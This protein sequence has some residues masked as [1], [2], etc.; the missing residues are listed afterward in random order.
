MAINKVEYN[1]E[2]LMDLTEDT[3]TEETLASGV[4]AHNAAGEP[5]TGTMTGGV[6]SDWAQTDETQLD[7]IKNKPEIKSEA[8]KDDSSLITSGGVYEA[9]ENG[10]EIVYIPVELGFNESGMPITATLVGVTHADI[11]GYIEQGKEPKLKA[12]SELA[13]LQSALFPLVFQAVDGTLIFQA[14]VPVEPYQTVN[15]IITQDNTILQTVQHLNNSSIVDENVDDITKGWDD[16]IPT[17]GASKRLISL[18]TNDILRPFEVKATI[19]ADGTLS[20]VSANGLSSEEADIYTLIS[21]AYNNDDYIYIEL[22]KPSEEKVFLQL[23]NLDVSK[24]V[25]TMVV[26]HG[27]MLL[28]AGVTVVIQPGNIFSYTT[29]SIVDDTQIQIELKKLEEI[30]NGKC[31]SFV[32][33]T[34]LKLETEIENYK[35]NELSEGDILYNIELKIGD[36]FLIKDTE[37]PDYWWNGSGISELETTNIDP[38]N[39]Y[40]KTEIDQG[41]TNLTTQFD[42]KLT[43]KQDIRNIQLKSNAGTEVRYY[44]LGLMAIDDDNNYGNFTFTGRLGGWTNANTAVYS[45]MLM[46]RGDY[47]GNI[48]TATVSA[49]GEYDAA[50]ELTDIVVAKNIDLS[51]SVYLKVTGNFCYN[52]DWTAYQHSIIYDGYYTTNEPTDIIWKLSEA[53]KTIFKSDGSFEASGDINATTIGGKQIVTSNSAPASGTSENIITFVY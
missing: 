7:Y 30:A 21:N 50:I 6:Q 43:K 38:N 3:V 4:T 48:I 28:F 25:F 41:L 24:A 49:S 37:V 10:K 45:I 46:N 47:T 16:Y 2:V 33:D 40:T 17:V 29:G 1:G 31:Q 23:T 52:F 11:L 51:H 14:T 8:I 35:N 13:G 15:I 42:T 12:S 5:I 26:K 32:F 39:Y 19:N 9:I 18:M 20:N 36:I 34:Q 53:P 44:R 22:I 27:E